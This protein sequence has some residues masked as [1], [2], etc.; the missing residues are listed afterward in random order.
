MIKKISENERT[1]K[2]V[3]N[4]N[5]SDDVYNK[6][7]TRRVYEVY[8]VEKQLALFTSGSQSDLQTFRTFVAQVKQEVN[9]KINE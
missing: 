1:L 5:V 9:S 4:T 7:V 6:E 2:S 3:K 8:P